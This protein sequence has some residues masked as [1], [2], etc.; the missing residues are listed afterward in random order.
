MDWLLAQFGWNNK[1]AIVEFKRYVEKGIGGEYLTEVL[2]AELIL[3]S[4][5][6]V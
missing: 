5:R 4:E 3:G 6:F 2:Q 1:Q